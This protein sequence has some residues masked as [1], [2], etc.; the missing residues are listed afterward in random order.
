MND[1]RHLAASLLLAQGAS[2]REIME[3]LGHDQMSL[4]SD[5]YNH[6]YEAAGK[7]N[8]DRMDKMLLGR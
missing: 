6:V 1:V 7:A 5:I 8:V 4:T 3:M 2:L